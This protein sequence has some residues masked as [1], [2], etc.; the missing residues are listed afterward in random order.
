M[1]AD[2][3]ELSQRFNVARGDSA[4]WNSAR[5]TWALGIFVMG[6][7]VFVVRTPGPRPVPLEYKARTV[8]T[9]R[10]QGVWSPVQ[11][12]PPRLLGLAHPGPTAGSEPIAPPPPAVEPLPGPDGP[13]GGAYRVHVV[14]E[15]ERLWT[16]AQRALGKGERWPEI[17]AANPGLD[18]KRLRPGT[19]LVIPLVAEATG[20]QGEQTALRSQAGNSRVGD[21]PTRDP[22]RARPARHTVQKGESLAVIARRY[23]T[24]ADWRRIRA[25]N[26]KLARDPDRV[27]AGVELVI[28]PERP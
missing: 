19:R 20:V 22:G 21:P 15:K 26:P 17:A 27:R 24:D 8:R 2:L 5:W 23:Y 9:E 18:V 1:A 3:R 25:A 28:P 12:E 16:I 7:I 13:S 10:V 14:R 4:R 11:P 6:V